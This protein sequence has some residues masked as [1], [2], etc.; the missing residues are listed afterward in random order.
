[1]DLGRQG[2]SGHWERHG[3]RARIRAWGL[4]RGSL[5]SWRA[6]GSH[7]CPSVTGE[8]LGL[9][10]PRWTYRRNFSGGELQRLLGRSAEVLLVAEGIGTNATVLLNGHEV[11]ST[12]DSWVRYTSPVKSLLDFEGSN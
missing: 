6:G 5:A 4:L 3:R 10:E 1:M 11:L 8:A 2:R 9:A 7:G 12:D